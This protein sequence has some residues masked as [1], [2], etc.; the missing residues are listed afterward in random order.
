[1]VNRNAANSLVQY[2]AQLLLF[3]HFAQLRR[4]VDVSEVFDFKE[5]GGGEPVLAQTMKEN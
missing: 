3:R 4:H 5:F 1:L 2:P